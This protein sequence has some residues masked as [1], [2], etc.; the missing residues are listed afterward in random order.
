MIP[1]SDTSGQNQNRFLPD[2][3]YIGKPHSVKKKIFSK[4]RKTHFLRDFPGAKN[5]KKDENTRL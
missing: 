2:S 4:A 1:F 5:F 3:H